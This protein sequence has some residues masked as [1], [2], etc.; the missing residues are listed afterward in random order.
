[1]HVNRNLRP[2]ILS[3]GAQRGIPNYIAFTGDHRPAWWAAFRHGYDG[4]LLGAI[5][6]TPGSHKEAVV[7]TSEELLVLEESGVRR[8]P[9]RDV[10]SIARLEKEPIPEIIQLTRKS[11]AVFELPIR[12]QTG[13]IGDV[14]RF[15]ICA[16]REF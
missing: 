15:L 9:Y 5:E 14:M 11:G 7:I 10:A 12:G 13:A 8:L 2:R 6:N 16:V 4:E 1:M 3:N